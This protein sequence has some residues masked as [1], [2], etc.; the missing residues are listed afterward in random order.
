MEE[1]AAST[2]S[3]VTILEDLLIAFCEV[4]PCPVMIL[5]IVEREGVTL[6]WV[7][8]NCNRVSKVTG[9]ED[10]RWE[11]ANPRRREVRLSPRSLWEPLLSGFSATAAGERSSFSQA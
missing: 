7:E 11:I 3:V 8:Q 10:D 5:D 2:T 1:R 4:K 6:K 9:S